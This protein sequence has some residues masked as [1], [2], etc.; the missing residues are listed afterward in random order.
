MDLSSF[1]AVATY[2]GLTADKLIPLLLV[3]GVALYIGYRFFAPV[4]KSMTRISNAC[5]EIQTVMEAGGVALRHHL[6]EAPGSPLRPTEYG[7]TLI[8]D[9]GL[10]KVLDEQKVFLK[11]ELMK[12]LSGSKTEYDVQEKARELLIEL[13]EKE[14]FDPVKKYAYQNGTNVDI[15]LKAGG[16]W[17]RDDFLGNPREANKEA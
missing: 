7:K 13:K 9:S 14:I 11:E 16:L 1:V 10:E 3:A 2:L 12:K 17:L 8:R 15:I 5:I 6:V 4:R